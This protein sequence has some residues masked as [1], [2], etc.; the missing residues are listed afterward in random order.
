VNVD[1]AMRVVAE[2][3]GGLQ[4]HPAHD[5]TRRGEAPL[6]LGK[7]WDCMLARSR[8][9]Q[10]RTCKGGRVLTMLMV[11]DRETWSLA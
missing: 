9:Q 2:V 3:T 1:R 5:A 7:R 8:E 4:V 10:R 11:E 6:D